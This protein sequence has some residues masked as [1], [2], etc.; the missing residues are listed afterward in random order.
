MGEP[1]AVE[2]FIEK[3]MNAI[4]LHASDT[5]D[6]DSYHIKLSKDFSSPTVRKE[7]LK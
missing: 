2:V 3:E 7:Y 4:G 1:F 6:P 5:G